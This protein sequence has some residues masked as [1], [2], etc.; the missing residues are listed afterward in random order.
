M[1]AMDK[2]INKIKETKNPTVMGLD[3]RYDMLPESVKSKY[4]TD[5]KSV[6]SAFW[7]YNKAL[8]DATFDIIPAIKPQSAFY[9]ALRSRWYRVT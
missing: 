3:P 9:E 5:V 8:I 6:C 4:G 2:L 7:E 1:N